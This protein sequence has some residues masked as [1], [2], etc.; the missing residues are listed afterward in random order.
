MS[1]KDQFQT[2]SSMDSWCLC[3]RRYNTVVIDDDQRL[4]GDL[5]VSIL[6]NAVAISIPEIVNI[7][8]IEDAL[9]NIHDHVVIDIK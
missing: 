2:G 9:L 4:I 7:A 3:L 5:S 6:E 8:I 1:Q